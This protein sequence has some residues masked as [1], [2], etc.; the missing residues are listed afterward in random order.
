VTRTGIWFLDFETACTSP[1][2]WDLAHA[3]EGTARAYPGRP[4]RALLG[5]CRGLVSV[6]TAAWCW[7]GVRAP[8]AA[9]AGRT[10]PG[11]G[12]NA[13]GPAAI[14]QACLITQQ[15]GR[16]RADRSLRAQN[17]HSGAPLAHSSTVTMTAHSGGYRTFAQGRR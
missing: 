4:N 5:V 2:E 10:P 1:L 12:E 8:G 13:D 11:G 7:G 3:G 9:L 15:H 14:A 16:G 17:V 6:K